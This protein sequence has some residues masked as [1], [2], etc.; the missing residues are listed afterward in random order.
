MRERE[1]VLGGGD[2]NRRVDDIYTVYSRE[3]T[4]FVH[5]VYYIIALF[6]VVYMYISIW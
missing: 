2:A 6:S 1:M 3:T 4:R 5:S